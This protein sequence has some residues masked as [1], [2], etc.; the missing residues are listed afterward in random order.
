M[1]KR[2]PAPAPTAL[3]VARGN[4]GKRALNH[5]EPVLPPADLSPPKGLKGRAL[6]EWQEKGP[7]Y[8]AAGVLTTGDMTFFKTYC[9]IVG[10]EDRYQKLADKVTPSEALDLGY[11]SHLVKIRAQLKQ[12]FDALGGTPSSRSGVKVNHQGW[13][14]P[15]APGAKA[16]D[17]RKKRFF[18]RK[19]RLDPPASE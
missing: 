14:P 5:D 4:P 15:E 10:D 17:A 8:L 19:L 11:A 6:Q 1:G 7:L 13:Q 2:G 18:G 9:Q 3:K 12:Y 16:A